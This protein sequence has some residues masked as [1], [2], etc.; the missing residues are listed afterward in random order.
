MIAGLIVLLSG[1][2]SIAVVQ[3]TVPSLHS[4]FGDRS[5]SVVAYSEPRMNVVTPGDA[6]GGGL[7]DDLTRPDGSRINI[8]SPSYLVAKELR[9][10]LA[11]N[12]QLKLGEVPNALAPAPEG[13]GSVSSNHDTLEV[14][15][16][17]NYLG[18]RPLGWQT[19]QY[20]LHAHARLLG[21]NGDM[22]WQGLCKIG[23]VS[24]DTTLQL[25]RTEFKNNDGARLTEI[26]GLA[27]DRCAAEIAGSLGRG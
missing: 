6:V 11:A 2:S 25:D 12:L 5:I 24:E 16:D 4:E 15:T 3:S 22:V 9:D 21:A 17:V 26:L 27:S 19:Y 20:M 13:K 7:I 8:P 1:C 18:Y 14:F 23:G 10:T